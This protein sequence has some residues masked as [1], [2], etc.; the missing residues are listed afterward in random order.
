M[1]GGAAIGTANGQVLQ[2]SELFR[3]PSAGN[4][5]GQTEIYSRVNNV[6][7]PYGFA[8]QSNTLTGGAASCRFASYA[9]L[10]LAV[11]WNRVWQRKNI[12]VAFLKV[13]D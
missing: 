4:G 11:N 2:P 12:P 3:K 5:G 7:H 9:D 8:F 10:K 6:W 1:F 13:N